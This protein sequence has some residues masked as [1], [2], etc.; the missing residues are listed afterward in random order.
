MA[1]AWGGASILQTH[2]ELFPTH[3]GVMRCIAQHLRG[4]TTTKR[5]SD[6]T[7]TT[8]PNRLHIHTPPTHP[9]KRLAHPRS[10]IPPLSTLTSRATHAHPTLPRSTGF[11]A[12]WGCISSSSSSRGSGWGARRSELREWGRAQ[13]SARARTSTTSSE[14]AHE[15][16]TTW[17]EAAAASETAS[18]AG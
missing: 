17:G 18:A 7:N 9:P 5:A 12:I 3:T 8:R 2:H 16:A 13:G 10:P 15:S 6:S 11:C 14:Q 1:G 4:S